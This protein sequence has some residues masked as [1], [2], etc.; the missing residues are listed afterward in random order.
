[1]P[2]DAICVQGL[3]RELNERTVGGRID[4]IYQPDKEEIILSIRS[5][6]GNCKLM[7]TASASAP[8]LHLIELERENP[9]VPPMFCMLLRK[10]LQGSKICGITQPDW[11]RMAVIELDTTDEMGVSTKK[12]LIC[13]MM[14]KYSN[15]ILCDQDKRILDAI[16]R[17]DGDVSGKR[18]VLPGLFYRMP[19]PQEKIDPLQ[20]SEAGLLAALQQADPAE[21]ADHWLLQKIK[22]LSPLV[23]RELVYQATG[24]TTKT[25]SELTLKD[26]QKL[27]S[28]WTA[29]LD[30]VAGGIFSPY[31][32]T[33]TED[34][35]V[36]DFS[37]L[38]IYQYGSRANL[39]NKESF[40]KLLGAFYEKKAKAERMKHRTQ[41]ITKVVTLARDRLRKKIGL[42]RK[43]LDK[44][45]DRD[46]YKHMGELITANLYQ[47][48]KG[49]K[50]VKVLD[51]FDENCPEIEIS[52]DL[53]LT[54]QQNAAQ[55]FKK[56][57]KAK[58]AEIMLTEQIQEGEQ[59]L[60]YLESV[61]DEIS[62]AENEQDLIQ[63]REELLETGYLSKKQQRCKKKKQTRK[64]ALGKPW[65][66]RTS[67]GFS[68]FAGRNNMQND[69]LTL[70]TAWKHDI[71]FHT[72]KIHG[73]HVILVCD[74]REPTNLAMT[75][76]AEIAAY[77]SKA[78]TSAMVPVDYS[79]VKNIKKPNGAKPG[80]VIYHVYQTAFVTP[81]EDKILSLRVTKS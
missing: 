29:F 32:L 3:V 4:K 33:H 75:E 25:I 45:Q 34:H 68:V 27:A 67:D 14:G 50:K 64:P 8:R 24:E 12:Y 15:I 57:N 30:K 10:H 53:R 19:P 46:R 49:V 61:L 42:Q 36:L 5:A 59:N 54:P 62:R 7:L 70:K 28:V 13:E 21:S 47:I 58:T 20:V 65:E 77:H 78:K 9:A 18:Q 81:D 31:L 1:M 69:M 74:G 52:L 39:E 22:G 71:W 51:Y 2:L 35:S 48:E 41:E 63:I 40:S 76:A 60:S 38:P 16:R 79:E 6:Q 17:V 55:Y 56:Y 73:S 23:C 44:T 11:E 80:M 66:Y 43:E 72:Q 26:Q 37:Y